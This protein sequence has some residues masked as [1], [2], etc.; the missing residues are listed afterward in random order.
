MSALGAEVEHPPGVALKA[1]ACGDRLRLF[2]QSGLPDP[3]LAA[4]D[5]DRA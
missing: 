2:D 4:H 1:H 5:H 3:R